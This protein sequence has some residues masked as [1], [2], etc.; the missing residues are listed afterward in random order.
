MISYLNHSQRLTMREGDSF[1]LER[2]DTGDWILA[3]ESPAE[4][5]PKLL[6]FL[7]DN[8][9]LITVKNPKAGVIET[10]WADF[11]GDEKRNV[12]YRTFGRMIGVEDAIPVDNRFRF[13]VTNGV[14]SGTA[15]VRVLHQ[16]RPPVSEGAEA[17][18][19][20]E[21]WDN[22]EERSKRLDNSL[23]GELLVYFAQDNMDSSVSRE[24]QNLNIDNLIT[25]E[26]DGNGNPVLTI[27]GISFARAWASVSAALDNVGLNV[28]DRNRSAGIF[29]LEEDAQQIDQPEKKKG[30][31]AG[32]FGSDD[33]EKPSGEES[34]DTLTVRV[35]NFP[36]VV[37]VSVEKDVNTSAP[38]DVSEKL[39][40]LI[41]DKMK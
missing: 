3:G 1:S 21:Q 4:I 12:M 32:L 20:P 8:E 19:E 10:E 37:Q 40:Q 36:E 30:F 18:S 17:G 2:S 25:L 41:H 26:K 39:L 6:A 22:L 15:E 28:I 35:S 14:K 27:R 16:G 23:L 24:A 33:K 7:E 29:Y 5:W 11:G 9:V 13:E 31:W 38:I 34:E